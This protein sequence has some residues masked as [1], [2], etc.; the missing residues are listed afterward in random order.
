MHK[1]RL[2]HYRSSG[3]SELSLL[4]CDSKRGET[5]LVSGWLLGDSP[6]REISL[7]GRSFLSGYR[8]VIQVWLF[9]SYKMALWHQIFLSVVEQS[10]QVCP[11]SWVILTN[12]FTCTSIMDSDSPNDKN[13][14]QNDGTDQAVDHLNRSEFS[15]EYQAELANS[16]PL[17]QEEVQAILD[18]WPGVDAEHAE[19]REQMQPEDQA[20][21]QGEQEKQAAD[22]LA[23]RNEPEAF[24]TGQ[25]REMRQ[26][27]HL[28]L[29]SVT[30]GQE[31]DK[32]L[33]SET[34]N[35][36]RHESRN[37]KH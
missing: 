9:A 15:D 14:V 34:Q 7:Q 30:P 11:Q 6:V 35:Q 23:S 20:E 26:S 12:R 19:L 17:N 24:A 2:N 10:N 21:E 36:E 37:P 29:P 18:A 33:L 32:Q 4:F 22:T 28:K 25:V 13:I 1:F 8:V 16:I 5:S 3:N 27:L 31:K